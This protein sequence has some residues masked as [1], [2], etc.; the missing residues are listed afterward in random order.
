MYNK[1]FTLAEMLVVVIIA[2]AVVV[3]AVPSFKKTQE[4]ARFDAA[5][6][7]LISLGGAVQS[8]REDLHIAGNACTYPKST[9]AVQIV[10]NHLFRGAVH[11][12]DDVKNYCTS[13][14]KLSQALF[15]LDYM[16][17]LAFDKDANTYKG[18]SFYVCPEG[19][20]SNP[21][22]CKVVGSE[23]PVACMQKSGTTDSKYNIA[24]YLEDTSIRL[25]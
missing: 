8:L 19:G 11:P 23:R 7:N 14:I 24:R 5:R 13:D 16:P 10:S 6:G 18:Y 22:C 25:K 12:L 9:S 20:A 1:G 3:L 15:E 17:N 2:A 4:R 21:D